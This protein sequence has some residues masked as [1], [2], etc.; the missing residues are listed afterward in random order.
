MFQERPQL[1]QPQMHRVLKSTQTRRKG[2]S[3]SESAEEEKQKESFAAAAS[4]R[5]DRLANQLQKIMRKVIRDFITDAK[6]MLRVR[7][8]WATKAYTEAKH[9]GC[10]AYLLA[11]AA[12]LGVQQLYDESLA[13]ALLA[14]QT[15]H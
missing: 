4:S 11:E 8:G 6:T 9:M 13:T 2:E 7:L 5:Q 3:L 12:E 15:C 14:W 10:V 1:I